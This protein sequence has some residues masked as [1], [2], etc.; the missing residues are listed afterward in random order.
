[1]GLGADNCAC[2]TPSSRIPFRTTVAP[3]RGNTWE[4]SIAR[5]E[6]PLRSR[7]KGSGIGLCGSG[8]GIGKFRVQH[9]YTEVTFAIGSQSSRYALDVSE[10]IAH[11]QGNKYMESAILPGKELSPDI[12]TW[13]TTKGKLHACHRTLESSLR[14][15]AYWSLSCVFI[16]CCPTPGRYGIRKVFPCKS[17]IGPE[18]GRAGLINCDPIT[19]CNNPRHPGKILLAKCRTGDNRVVWS[20]AKAQGRIVF[21]LSVHMDS[22]GAVASAL[23]SHLGDPGSIPDGFGPGFS[24]VGIVLDDAACRWVFSGHFRFPRP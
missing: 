8:D 14:S 11:V 7:R 4:I 22:G 16:G 12:D 18:A 20:L 1:M 24:Q 3:G 21:S 9:V 10:P 23:A 17:T 13:P 5:C 19:E 6:F 15:S 2:Q